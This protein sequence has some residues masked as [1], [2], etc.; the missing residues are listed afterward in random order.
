MNE[1]LRALERS[2]KKSHKI[3]ERAQ[4]KHSR[5]GKDKSLLRTACYLG[6]IAHSGGIFKDGKKFVNP[7]TFGDRIYFE[8]VDEYNYVEFKNNEFTDCRNQTINI[9]SYADKTG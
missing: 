8:Q 6:S 4:K 3:I 9:L 1:K 2:I 5:A 7:M